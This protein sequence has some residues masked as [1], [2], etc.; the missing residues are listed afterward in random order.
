MDETHGRRKFLRRGAAGA[1]SL[2]IGAR[3][4]AEEAAAPGPSRAGIDPVRVG[5]VGVGG[6]GTALLGILL[7][8]EGVEVRAV[9]DLLEDR[10]AKAQ[11]LAAAAGRAGR[12]ATP[13]A[14]PTSSGSARPRNWTW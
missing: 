10:V 12:P 11:E 6:R 9:C 3:S 13:A 5:F 14:R 1:V 4:P 2:A 7:G 8:L